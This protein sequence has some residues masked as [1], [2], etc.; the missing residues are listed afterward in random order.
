M[1]A[2]RPRGGFWTAP[3]P[4]PAEVEKILTRIV[5]RAERL[6]GDDVQHDPDEDE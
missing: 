5:A 1:A 3:A 4:T 2:T 6:F